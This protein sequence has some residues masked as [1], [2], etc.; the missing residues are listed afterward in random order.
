MITDIL[1][2]AV[3]HP[4]VSEVGAIH[5]RPQGVQPALN[6]LLAHGAGAPMESE[7]MGRTAEGLVDRGYGVMRFRY[8]YMERMSQEQRRFPPDRTPKL[9]E[10][11]LA[12]LHALRKRTATD[13]IVLAGKSMGGRMSS[14]LAAAG[15]SC[16]GLLYLGYPLHPAGK[17]DKL[18]SEH[19]PKIRQ[20]SLFVQ[21]TRDAL[22]DLDLLKRELAAYGAP[23]DLS[24]I[25]GGDHSFEVLKRSG[26][27]PG[28]VQKELLDVMDGWLAKL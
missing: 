12:A 15:E 11:H 5:Q 17:P 20:R 14:H 25:A 27:T 13:R 28:E 6:V 19:F 7:F 21:G 1:Q 16:A 23:F 24:I 3:D 10:V 9:E 26:R 22:C 8:G 4:H 2:V 18:R